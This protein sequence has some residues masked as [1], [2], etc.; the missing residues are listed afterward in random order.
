MS[1]DTHQSL[2]IGGALLALLALQIPNVLLWPLPCRS[3]VEFAKASP[4]WSWLPWSYTLFLIVW[5]PLAVIATARTVEQAAPAVF[6]AAII[7]VPYSGAAAVI[8]LFEAFTGLSPRL[9][10]RQPRGSVQPWLH[11]S[12]DFLRLGTVQVAGPAGRVR[13]AGG[14]R[15]ALAALSL[16]FM[17]MTLNS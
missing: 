14:L 12:F 13:A 3:G 11:T 16:G 9:G 6:L 15:L 7:L 4:A 8:G 10:L 1:A 5:T 2:I 17:A